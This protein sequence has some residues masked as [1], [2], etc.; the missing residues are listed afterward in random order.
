MTHRQAAGCKYYSE[1]SNK[2]NSELDNKIVVNWLPLKCVS[3]VVWKQNLKIFI[4]L[5]SSKWSY[6]VFFCWWLTISSTLV[7][8]ILG[9]FSSEIHAEARQSPPGLIHLFHEKQ[10][11]YC[12]VS[13]VW[14]FFKGIT[15]LITKLL[16]LALVA[17]LPDSAILHV[18]NTP[19]WRKVFP[20]MCK[21]THSN[22]KR[23]FG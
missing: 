4:Y 20:K 23:Y 7:L 19:V 11:Q 3:K 8:G 9:P 2:I 5:F 10:Q 22:T 21:S 1:S 16:L 13:A 17:C 15:E 6:Y 14:A 18:L 12:S